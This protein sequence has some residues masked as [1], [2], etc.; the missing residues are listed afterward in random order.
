[1]KT[2]PPIPYQLLYADRIPKL[3]CSTRKRGKA[4]ERSIRE[5][6]NRSLYN[7]CPHKTPATCAICACQEQ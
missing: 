5:R 6:E 1:M 4:A 3:E 2:A 7:G